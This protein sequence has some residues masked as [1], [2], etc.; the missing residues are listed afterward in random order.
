MLE[1]LLL[2]AT[3]AAAFAVYVVAVFLLAELLRAL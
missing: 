1:D 3:G 2:V